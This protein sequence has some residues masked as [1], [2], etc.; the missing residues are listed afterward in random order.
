[1]SFSYFYSCEAALIFMQMNVI[2]HNIHHFQLSEISQTLVIMY[3]I[4]RV[5]LSVK[6][7]SE[8]SIIF[9]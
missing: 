2:I 7:R 3:S 5:N 6:I 1:M 9:D 8:I 4:L